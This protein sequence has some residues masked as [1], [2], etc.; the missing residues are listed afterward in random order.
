MATTE[1]KYVTRHARR[2]GKIPPFGHQEHPSIQQYVAL[3][4]V[5]LVAAVV[6]LIVIQKL[7]TTVTDSLSSQADIETTVTRSVSLDLPDLQ[8][9]ILLSDTEIQS[10][11][12]A[13]DVTTYDL[14]STSSTGLKIVKLPSDVSTLDAA[15]Y[16]ATGIKNLDAISAA[17]ILKGSWELTTTSTG[18]RTVKIHYA[19]FDSDS[20]E[21]AVS[22]A[23]EAEFSTSNVTVSDSGT[24]ENGN[25]YESG[26]VV[27]DGTTYSWNVSAC[28]LSEIYSITGLP[29]DAFYVGLKINS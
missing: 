20:L 8:S 15:T 13:S 6:A 16:Y 3:G 27:I 25:T 17:K 18:T 9:Y 4:V 23:V 29:T 26:T 1:A 14:S 5:L 11:L 2:T 10:D 12:E 21:D 22:A 28:L 19:D 24:D 7:L